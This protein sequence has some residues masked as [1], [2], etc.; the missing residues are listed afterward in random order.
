[1]VAGV[2]AGVLWA[3]ENPEAGIVEPDDLDYR[4]MLNIALP[5]LGKVTGAY[6]DWTPLKNRERLFPEQHLDKTDPWQ[7][8]NIRVI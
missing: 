4:Y 8:I 5:Y 1:V 7:F 6:T 2:L 3:I